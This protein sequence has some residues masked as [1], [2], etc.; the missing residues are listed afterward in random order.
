MSKWRRYISDLPVV[1]NVLKWSKQHSLPGLQGVPIYDILYFIIQETQKDGISTR[2]NSV[3]FSFFLAI[4]PTIIFA[5]TLIPLLPYSE[6]YVETVNQA[7]QSAL[8]ASAGSYLTGVI[9]DIASIK[10]GGLLSVGVLLSVFFASSGMLTLMI[11]F[12]KSYDTFKKRTY[13]RKRVVALSL[14]LLL[15]VLLIVSVVLIII[16]QSALDYVLN[17]MG[18]DLGAVWLTGLRL[19]SSTLIVYTGITII[20][21]YGPSL[22]RRTKFLNAGAIVATA[23]SILTSIGFSYFVNNFGRYNELYGSIGALIVILLWLQFNATILL[24]GF[25]LNAA[26]AVNRDLRSTTTA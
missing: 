19:L 21:K 5:F 3:A 10:R 11:G 4:F 1:G 25:E 6:Y 16:G 8:P 9:D 12:D 20:Y 26:I 13:L 24:I 14:T 18:I 2:A 22:M 17:L 15:V 23:G 7:I